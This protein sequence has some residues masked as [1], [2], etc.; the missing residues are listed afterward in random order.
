MR[1]VFPDR[2]SVDTGEN[3]EIL[4]M[5]YDLDKRTQIPAADTCAADRSIPHA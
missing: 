1:R 5:L 4:H 2:P 3:E